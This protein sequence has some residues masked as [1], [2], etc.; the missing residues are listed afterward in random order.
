MKTIKIQKSWFYSAGK[1]YGWEMKGLDGRGV[2]LHRD[3]LYPAFKAGEDLTVIVDNKRYLVV[4]ADAIEFI[5]KHKSFY[6]MP[7]GTMI[8]VISKSICECLD[9]EEP[10]QKS[11]KLVIEESQRTLL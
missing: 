5:N 9:K 7:R 6:K 4:P 2:G 8:G 11:H 1:K 3:I 10:I